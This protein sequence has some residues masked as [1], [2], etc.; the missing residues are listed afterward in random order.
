M[1]LRP[2]E[3]LMAV[4]RCHPAKIYDDSCSCLYIDIFLFEWFVKKMYLHL[5]NYISNVKCYFWLFLKLKALVAACYRT[6]Y[7][8]KA[9]CENRL[10][11]RVPWNA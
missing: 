3:Q 7:Y 1:P 10:R 6:S 11:H 2:T 9:A 5:I 8:V 4:Q